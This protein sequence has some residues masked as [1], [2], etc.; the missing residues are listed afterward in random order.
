MLPVS[1]PLTRLVVYCRGMSLRVGGVE[2]QA[3]VEILYQWGAAFAPRHT[4]HSGLHHRE[5]LLRPV[6]VEHWC[7]KSHPLSTRL[8][9]FLVLPVS[10]SSWYWKLKVMSCYFRLLQRSLYM[11][12]IF[13]YRVL[14]LSTILSIT[15][16]IT[17]IYLEY[18][19][20]F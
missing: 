7:R 13:I 16:S 10:R 1:H 3:I 9:V 20:K 6:P 11:Y 8:P 15:K 19:T 5:L 4:W 12:L 18:S 17:N 14:E 2:R